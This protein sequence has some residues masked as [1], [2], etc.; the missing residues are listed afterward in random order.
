MAA[1]RIIPMHIQK[2][3]T[4]AKSLSARLDYS[5]NPEKT[6]GGELISSYNCTRRPLTRNSFF[7]SNSTNA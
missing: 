1:T 7:P 6:D 3:K 5:Q 2:G 4:L